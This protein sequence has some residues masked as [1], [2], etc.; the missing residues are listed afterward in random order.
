VG[1]GKRLVDRQRFGPE[2]VVDAG[3][4]VLDAAGVPGF[5]MRAV[6]DR[7]GTYPATVYWHVGGRSQLLT[8]IVDRVLAEMVPPGPQV[9]DWRDWLREVAREY[10]RVLHAHPNTGQFVASVLTTG[11]T[12][13]ELMEGILNV[14][15][16]AGFRGPRLASAYNVLVGSVVGWVSVELSAPPSDVEPGWQEGFEASLRDLSPEQF[17]TLAANRDHVVGNVIGLRWTGGSQVP[18]DAAFEMALDVWIAGLSVQAEPQ[19]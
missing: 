9:L 1:E 15:A 6:A 11:V 16:R 5:T 2:V 8:A 14:L 12:A 17:P 19:G 3:L 13:P 10:R 7:L 4:A 18:L